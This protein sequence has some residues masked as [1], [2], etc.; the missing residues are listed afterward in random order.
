MGGAAQS[1][2]ED[3]ESEDESET[4]S[5]LTFQKEVSTLLIHQWY[6]HESTDTSSDIVELSSLGKRRDNFWKQ[7]VPF[8]YIFKDSSKEL[9]I[10]NQLHKSVVGS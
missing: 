6:N 10:I 8:Y 9:W 5:E 7:T 3:D 1:E 2:S 4:E